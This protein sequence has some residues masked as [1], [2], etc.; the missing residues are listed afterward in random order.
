MAHDSVSL[1]QELVGGI[2]GKGFRGRCIVAFE[3]LV[4]GGA[5]V[6]HRVWRFECLY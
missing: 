2:S 3:E 1:L 6:R 5:K 4:E